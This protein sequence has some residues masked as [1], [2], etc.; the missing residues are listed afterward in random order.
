MYS[1]FIK[2]SAVEFK[3]IEKK[4][5]VY[6]LSKEEEESK[7][8]DDCIALAFLLYRCICVFVIFRYDVEA[9]NRGIKINGVAMVN[10]DPFKRNGTKRIFR[11]NVDCSEA[12]FDLINRMES[13]SLIAEIYHQHRL[14][15]EGS[16]FENR[17]YL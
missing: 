2:K 16:I 9:I 4:I 14:G 12:A 1:I 6:L 3:Y 15:D 10:N 17:T 11:F 8:I 13:A 5:D 7:K